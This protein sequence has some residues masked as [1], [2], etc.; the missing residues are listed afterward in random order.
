M[1][2]SFLWWL[3]LAEENADAVL[4]LVG[5]GEWGEEEFLA[6]YRIL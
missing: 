2:R 3:R 4:V 1:K 5:V 6:L